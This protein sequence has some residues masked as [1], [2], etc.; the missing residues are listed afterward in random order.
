[1]VLVSPFVEPISMDA[2]M[3]FACSRASLLVLA[4]GSSLQL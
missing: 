4:V 2:A 1:L 3:E